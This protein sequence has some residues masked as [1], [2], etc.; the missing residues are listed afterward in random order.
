MRC[1]SCRATSDRRRAILASGALRDDD[2]QV[3]L[4]ALL[5]L[6]EMPAS[7]AVAARPRRI[8]ARRDWPRETAR[9]PMRPSSPP[10]PT[11][12]RSWGP[13]GPA[14]STGRRAARSS[15]SPSGSPSITPAAC[16]ADSIV[17]TLAALEG[18]DRRVAGAVIAGLARGWPEGRPARAGRRDRRRRWA[19]CCRGS[20]PRRGGSWSGWPTAG[21]RRGS[22]GTRPRSP[23]RSWRQARDE[24]RPDE[25]RVDA[26]RQFVELRKKDPEAARELIALVTPRTPPGAGH[27]R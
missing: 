6:A 5:A 22:S 21:G 15:R 17:S 2:A 27:R 14:S 13:G 9:W 20:P 12:G 4:A 24:S 7:E 19:A 26:A 3:R 8:P 23:G 11:T 25:A 10:R 18:A 1:W 16:P